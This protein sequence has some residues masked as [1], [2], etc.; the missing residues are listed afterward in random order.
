MEL[1]SRNLKRLPL[2]ALV[3]VILFGTFIRLFRLE[4]H[5]LWMDELFTWNLVRLPSF[6]EFWQTYVLQEL[7]PPLY[8]LLEFVFLRFFE[9]SEWG[10][11]FPS[12][13]FGV[14]FIVALFF[15]A[16]ELEGI[17][18]GVVAAA[19]G[20]TSYTA[21]I[22]SQ[23]ARS[24]SLLLFM[25][26]LSGWAWVK[27]TRSEGSKPRWFSYWL[28]AALLSFT[29][30]F[31]VLMV[32]AQAFSIPLIE[33]F[34]RWKVWVG[35]F[36]LCALTFLPWLFVALSSGMPKLGWIQPP[37]LKEIFDAHRE[38]FGS[39]SV[40][41]ILALLLAFF[42]IY[43]AR[44]RER[45]AILTWVFT[46]FF[47]SWA[48][49]K[50]NPIYSFRYYSVTLAPMLVLAALGAVELRRF[51]RYLPPVIAV[52]FCGMGLYETVI[53]RQ[54]FSSPKNQQVREAAELAREYRRSNPEAAFVIVG[55]IDLTLY[56]E[57]GGADRE[58]HRAQALSVESWRS[59]G[60]S[61]KAVVVLAYDSVLN[62][63]EL[64]AHAGETFEVEEK[65]VFHRMGVALLKSRAQNQPQEQ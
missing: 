28:A 9:F 41:A 51:G 14:G 18:A 2:A 26:A 31:G 4:R 32:M 19:F 11:R 30:Y 6:H 36:T 12:V 61:R 17:W 56:Y 29:H 53:H 27:M 21:I 34:K 64:S 49:S 58:F 13:F 3:F 16:K 37:P 50:W 55:P 1:A 46:P 47:L 40:N 59:L 8:F 57:P 63:D 35:I 39:S 62:L 23:E 65:K 42:A 25:S 33:G 20:A 38:L 54:Y 10:L 52:I 48:I 43:A 22:F 7:T 44:R 15:F 24:Y 5:S 60:E 45:W